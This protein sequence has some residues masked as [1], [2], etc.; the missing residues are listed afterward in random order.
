M[1][2]QE[3][4]S[5]DGS[6]WSSVTVE[7]WDKLQAPVLRNRDKDALLAMDNCRWWNQ[8]LSRIHSQHVAVEVKFFSGVR[9]HLV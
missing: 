8:R 6:D 9:V 1:D 7:I 3:A 2:A 5:F 4:P